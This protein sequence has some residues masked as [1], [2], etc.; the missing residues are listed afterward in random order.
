MVKGVQAEWVACCHTAFF[1][2]TPLALTCWKDIIAAS[3]Q[4]TGN[5][6]IL[7]AITGICTSVLSKHTA[8][9]NSI[10]FSSDGA[11]LVSGSRD[12]TAK[13]WDIQT[14]GVIKSSYNHS[15]AVLSVSISPDSTVIASGTLN[16]TVHLWNTWTGEC[17][18]IIDGHVGVINSVGF[19]T[20][21][22][23]LLISASDDNTI[24][25][26]DTG[27]HQIGPTYK[28][29]HT[30]FSSDGTHFILWEQGGMVATVRNSNSGEI[31]AEL[32][33]PGDGFL[34]CCLSHDGKFMAGGTGH[35]IHIWDTTSS[36]PQPIETFTGH[37]DK[38]A[39]LTFSSSFISLSS[40]ISSSCDDSIK[41]WQFNTSSTDLVTADLGSKSP[42]LASIQSISLQAAD[43]IAISSDSA[44]EVKTWDI[45]TGLCKASFQTPAKPDTWRDAQLME[46]SVTF[47]WLE[48]QKI[49]IW[50]AQ[51]GELIKT[52][53][54][55]DHCHLMDLRISGDKSKVF[56]LDEKFIRAWSI[57]TGELV[58]EVRLECKP[59][60]DPI[61]VNGSRAWVYLKNSQTQGWDFGIPG[62]APIPLSNKPLNRPHL[63]FIGVKQQDTRKSRIED[64]VTGREVFR[65][66]GRY[67]KP[68]AA[69]WDGQYLVA[70]YDSGEVLILD[71]NHV[72]PQ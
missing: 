6:I 55:Y 2:C 18:C 16:A 60:Y 57:Q 58:G 5:I 28:G 65:L 47:V 69:Q 44:G 66:S 61:I 17:R 27:G 39:S 56:L 67:I 68:N 45:L 12:K 40:L 52:L 71:F 10:T 14:G 3:L 31:V 4:Y 33:S 42:V 54:V 13:L 49:Y 9:V 41:F 37:L 25:Q 26:W 34:Y 62:S 7:D 1:D 32:Q 35:I 11:L 64:T 36:D 59:T 70:G 63:E 22:S 8:N 72:I 20:I 21:N 29:T 50:D 30:S 48:A 51:K 46:G 19:S 43:G 23:Q 53:N 24:R 15:S 38:I